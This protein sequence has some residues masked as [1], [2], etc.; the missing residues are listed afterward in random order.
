MKGYYK[1]NEA[2][3]EVFT[4][5]GWFIT[6]D[7][8]YLDEDGFLFITGRSKNVIVGPS[9]ENIYPEAI[10]AK[11]LESIYVEETLVYE[12]DKQIVARV[13]P[14][15]AYIEGLED[16]RE[17]AQ[18]GRDIDKILEEI[19]KEVN[20][21]LPSFSKIIKIIE[22]PSPFIKTPTNKIKR[23]EYVPSYK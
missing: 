17:D 1:N 11:L 13:Y 19:R 23:M 15:Y 2:T 10:E 18:V 8:G 16:N 9:G 20:L 3:S 5:D 12:L 4:K 21:Q 6:G 14:D 22:Q 7:K